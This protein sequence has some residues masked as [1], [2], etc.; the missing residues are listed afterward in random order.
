MAVC[1][2][3]GAAHLSC[4]QRSRSDSSYGLVEGG[5]AS[6]NCDARAFRDRA[7]RMGRYGGCAKEKITANKLC[8]EGA[9]MGALPLFGPVRARRHVRVVSTFISRTGR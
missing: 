9:R 6:P 8:W 2:T 3:N 1:A 7:S 5:K 4:R